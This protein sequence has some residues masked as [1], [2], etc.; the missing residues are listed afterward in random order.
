MMYR[1]EYEDNWGEYETLQHYPECDGDGDTESDLDDL[2]VRLYSQ[3]HHGNIDDEE[4]ETSDQQNEV[5]LKSP[6]KDN[7]YTL[8]KIAVSNLSTTVASNKAKQETSKSNASINL[9]HFLTRSGDGDKSDESDQVITINQIKKSKKNKEKT[10]CK[11]KRQSR[12][13]EDEDSITQCKTKKKKVKTKRY[14]EKTDLKHADGKIDSSSSDVEDIIEVSP[15]TKPTKVDCIVVTDTEDEVIVLGDSDT[16]SDTTNIDSADAIEDDRINQG[17]EDICK[18][19]SDEV[20]S[21]DEDS[22]DNDE[23]Y[24]D[25]DESKTD[26]SEDD[27]EDD[28]SDE[29][30]NNEDMALDIDIDTDDEDDIKV[31]TSGKPAIVLDCSELS[32]IEDMSLG[33][34]H[35]AMGECDWSI[36]PADIP[37]FHVST[38][39]RYFL[40]SIECRNCRKRGHLSKECP[41]PKKIAVCIL[42]G[43]DGHLQ[44]NC[45]NSLCLNCSLP[46]H[47][48]RNCG[49]PQKSRY[50]ECNRC[51]MY[52]HIN[53]ECPDHWRQF[54]LSTIPGEKLV[55]GSKKYRENEITCCYNCGMDTHFGHECDE[56]RINQYINPN[57][58]FVQQYNRSV[59]IQLEQGLFDCSEHEQGPPHK[60]HHITFGEHDNTHEP[61]KKRFKA[62]NQKEPQ[63]LMSVQVNKKW[64]SFAQN[65]SERLQTKVTKTKSKKQMRKEKELER[66]NQHYAEH[67]ALKQ[68]ASGDFPRGKKQSS[69][70]KHSRMQENLTIRI[71][72]DKQESNARKVGKC[73]QKKM[74]WWEGN[75]KQNKQNGK[76]AFNDEHGTEWWDKNAR[77][78]KNKQQKIQNEK[79]DTNLQQS[80]T[81]LFQN[82]GK[83]NKKN[84][85]RGGF[86]VTVSNRGFRTAHR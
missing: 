61:P 31:H 14:L 52:G 39:G 37:Q 29:S 60:K 44:R 80:N 8:S 10:E 21:F 81:G 7:D 76:S 43:L 77:K 27:D 12:F 16:N 49:A 11:N 86:K 46:G 41:K 83:Q 45:P 38:R 1:S 35:N 58:P 59:S 65:V 26:E 63:N 84:Q 68:H 69:D 78:H 40:K 24:E 75:R 34:I 5:L 62:K 72:E 17:S 25:V 67:I 42:C 23:E 20:M 50:I 66:A 4:Q 28:V 47:I 22:N 18:K 82:K 33:D 6:I 48:Q 74:A 36:D 54:H 3:I 9:E 13:G 70:F 56:P 85:G 55:M 79:H 73:K 15:K 19:S 2:E 71:Q 51:H 57:L 30:N 64:A 53:R 32:D